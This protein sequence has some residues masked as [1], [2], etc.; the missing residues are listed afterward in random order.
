VA[1]RRKHEDSRRDLRLLRDPL[2]VER[3][4]LLAQVRALRERLLA[5]EVRP[6][7]LVHDV[8]RIRKRAVPA[9]V[10]DVQVRVHDDVD[11]RGGN[12]ELL[13]L[14]EQA[15]VAVGEE[16]AGLRSR[17]RVDEQR[18]IVGS[19]Q[20]D[21]HWDPPGLVVVDAR[22]GLAHGG[23]AALAIGDD[24]EGHSGFRPAKPSSTPC[25]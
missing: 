6:V 4:Y 23:E 8:A 10:I 2:H 7:L 14:F 25:Q 12:A 15:C 24:V 20:Y 11:I 5:H 9:D 22:K 19:Q 18:R 17:T 13:Q 3:Q 16:G 21:V 1:G